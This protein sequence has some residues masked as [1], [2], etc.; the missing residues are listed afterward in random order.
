MSRQWGS[1]D[2]KK[3][4]VYYILKCISKGDFVQK[5]F[6]RLMII[7]LTVFRFIF[8][9]DS[10][11]SYDKLP[12]EFEVESVNDVFV[13]DSPDANVSEYPTIIKLCHQKNAE[14]NGKLF[15]AFE[16][17]GGTYPVYE[18]VDDGKTWEHISMVKDNFNEGYYNEWMPF[19]YELPA[20]IGDFEKGT[21]ILAATSILGAGD[22]ISA[23]TITLYSSTDLG[24][25]WNAFC[26]VDKAGGIDW[27]VWEPYFIYEEETGRL[28]C[29]YS[30]DSDPEHSQKLVYKYTTD[31]V[32]WSEKFECVACKDSALR[33]GMPSVTK[34]G[35]GEYIMTYEIVGKKSAHIYYKKTTSL[36]NW[37]DVSDYGKVVSATGKTL[38]SAPYVAWTPAGSECGTLVVVAHHSAKYGSK[39]GSDMFL[40]FD[41]GKTFVPVDNPIPYSHEFTER[42]GYSPSL[43]FSEDGGTLY[44]VNNPDCLGTTY[45]ITM[46]KIKIS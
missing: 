10:N 8:S 17:W 23:S 19:L 37:G 32:N 5:I 3:T 41:Y 4:K 13:P 45:K 36:D 24:R 20:K 18:S 25:T 38:G 40:S 15:V 14:D 34:M 39:T 9:F 46:A 33:P 30:D 44:Y 42:C 1:L 6:F 28:F 21:I 22:N 26:N 16:K 7:I 11:V 12:I 31:L 35:N 2:N 27:G 29:F 43:F